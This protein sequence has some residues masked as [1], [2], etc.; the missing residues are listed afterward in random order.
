MSV[1]QCWLHTWERQGVKTVTMDV[2]C[3]GSGQDMG[4]VCRRQEGGMANSMGCYYGD[5]GRGLFQ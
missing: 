5:Q 4:N 3:P 2:D 1:W